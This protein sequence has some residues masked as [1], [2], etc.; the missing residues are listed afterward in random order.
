MTSFSRKLYLHSPAAAEDF[1]KAQRFEHRMNYGKH[2]TLAQFCANP[3][4]SVPFGKRTQVPPQHAYECW[5]PDPFEGSN[6]I[7][8]PK[9]V[10]RAQ[11]SFEARK[12][13]AE[14]HGIE[15]TDVVSQRL[16]DE[17]IKAR[18]AARQHRGGV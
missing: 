18:R 14:H 3:A 17:L 10:L 1:H 4:P 11:N 16:D 6:R 15:I 8:K 2:V 12:A 13:Y 7:L 5:M 9:A